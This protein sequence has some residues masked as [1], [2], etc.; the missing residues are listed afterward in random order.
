MTRK[1]RLSKK[2]Y[3]RRN[4]GMYGY[5]QLS[6]IR[7]DVDPKFLSGLSEIW[8]MPI[9]IISLGRDGDLPICPV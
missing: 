7:T 1:N 9:G 5:R 6:L 3:T 2:F 8:I 4:I